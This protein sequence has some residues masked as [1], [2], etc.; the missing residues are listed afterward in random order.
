MVTAVALLVVNDSNKME[1][2]LPAPSFKCGF[3]ALQPGTTTNILAYLHKSNE[4]Q[5]LILF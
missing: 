5:L 2:F 4:S 1:K 3:P